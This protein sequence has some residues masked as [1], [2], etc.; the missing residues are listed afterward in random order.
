[1]ASL[2]DSIA[3]WIVP[4]NRYA[5]RNDFKLFEGEY[6]AEVKKDKTK[7]GSDS[8]DLIYLEVGR[9]LTYWEGVE[10]TLARLFFFVT[11]CSDLKIADVIRRTF[12]SI[13]SSAARLTVLEDRLRLYL[14]PHKD[15]N[16]VK[17]VVDELIK[18]IRCASHRRNEIAH[19]VVVK[20]INDG[21]LRPHGA[22]GC[23]L[24]SPG[25]M[26][27]RNDL[28]QK[29]EDDPMWVITSKF[30]YNA[31]DLRILRSKF[32]DLNQKIM[33]YFGK[34]AKGED[35]IPH[36]VTDI[37][38]ARLKYENDKVLRGKSRKPPQLET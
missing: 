5:T 38:R 7:I 16:E 34:L 6:W 24:I 13:E 26:T 23:Y 11:E 31:D 3:L 4:T 10:E 18:S 32:Q 22:E 19:G 17:W 37:R 9:T 35:G 12:G 29:P 30:C 27:G 14:H 33:H 15:L 36:M 2:S 21:D 25:Y 28:H 1:M 8:P 20:F